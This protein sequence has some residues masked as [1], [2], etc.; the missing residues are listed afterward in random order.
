MLNLGE[1]MHAVVLLL[2]QGD[3]LPV[4]SPRV[5]DSLARWRVT[6]SLTYYIGFKM[7][8]R[9]YGGNGYS[10]IL[11]WVV[12][13]LKREGVGRDAINKMLVENPKRILSVDWQE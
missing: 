8:L 13:M 2:G 3:R 7:D 1:E 9:S 5:T 12:P 6:K 10:H 11:T 4:H